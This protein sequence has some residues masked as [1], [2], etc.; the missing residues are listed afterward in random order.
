M[1]NTELHLIK[2]VRFLNQK[3]KEEK[4][5]PISVSVNVRLSNVVIFHHLQNLV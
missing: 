3:K 4:H 2:N 5:K 1:V